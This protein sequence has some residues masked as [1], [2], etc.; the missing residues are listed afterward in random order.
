MTIRVV[1]G[2]SGASGARVGARVVALLAKSCT[3]HLVVS[4]GAERTIAHE[5]DEVESKSLAGT[6]CVRHSID[7]IGAEIASGSFETAG[8]IIVPCSMRT[9]GAVA[10]GNADNLL[11]RAADVHLKERRRLVLAMRESPLHLGH[12]RAMASVTEFGAIVAPLSPPFY[13]RPSSLAELVDQTAR[14]LVDLLALPI[15]RCGAEWAGERAAS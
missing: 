13:L 5:L 1:V 7:D 2:I 6:D 15:E 10:T 3:T 14:R 9:L 12:I 4:R 11:V 8:M